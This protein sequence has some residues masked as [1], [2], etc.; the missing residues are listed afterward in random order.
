MNPAF[1][2]LLNPIPGPLP[3]GSDGY[4]TIN[5]LEEQ[6]KPAV[7]SKVEDGKM[8][9][10]IQDPNWSQLRLTA[11]KILQNESKHLRAAMILAVAAAKGNSWP[12]VSDAL[13]LMEK[14]LENFW[15]TL[16]PM[17]DDGDPY[18]RVNIIND[19]SHSINSDND[20]YN[21]VLKIHRLPVAESPK[22]GRV[23]L[24]DHEVARGA[25]N[26]ALLGDKP[27][28]TPQQV[29]SI[30][31]SAKPD[32]L[33]ANADAIEVAAGCLNRITDLLVGKAGS[34]SKPSVD[35]LKS[36][37]KKAR[38]LL[39]PYLDHPVAGDG[40]TAAS[41]EVAEGGVPVSGS[42]PLNRVCV[43]QGPVN[44]REQAIAALDAVMD[45]YKR[46]E[47]SSPI[48]LML[49]RA[50]TL[51]NM[52]FFEILGDLT[53]EA[54]DRLKIIVGERATQGENAGGGQIDSSNT[55]SG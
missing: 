20:P 7:T 39:S 23:S 32:T 33:K 25:A 54:I 13:L 19:L 12:E 16:H 40:A 15:D 1:E 34:D 46:A 43:P 41:G 10:S 48:P 35:L 45:Y 51:A 37:L 36:T 18:Q 30:F 17:P 50:K 49:A 2:A 53:P 21:F 6:A 3:T 44:S 8:V 38:E 26:A 24:L 22:A 42:S 9:D 31:K 28:L 5:E 14:L 4:I 55:I 47:P 27:Q 52:N 29:S 11:I